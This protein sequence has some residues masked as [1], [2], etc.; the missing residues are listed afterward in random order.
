MPARLHRDEVGLTLA[1]RARRAG[2]A[3]QFDIAGGVELG[4]VV[5]DQR[6]QI[7]GGEPG[8]RRLVPGE[9]RARIAL[10]AGEMRHAAARQHH[11]LEPHRG[12]DIG[13]RRAKGPAALDRRLRRQIGVDPDRQDRVGDAEMG[14]RDADRVIDP[15]GAGEGRVEASGVEAADQLEA[16][17]ARHPPIEPAA[18]ELALGLGADMDREGRRHGVEELLGM[19]VRKDDPEVGGQR[20]EPCAD[21]GRGRL[22]PLDRVA[23]LGLRHREELRGVGQHGPA[24]DARH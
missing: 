9:V 12:D 6:F 19:V 18:G 14:Q 20:L 23:V 21:L 13:D 11:G 22:D 24:D 1:E 3:A 2:P 5:A 15:G 4:F 17:F 16:D 7:A 8:E 10:G